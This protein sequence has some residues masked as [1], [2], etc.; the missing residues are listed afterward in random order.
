LLKKRAEYVEKNARGPAA[1]LTRT[2]WVAAFGALT[3]GC[4][5]KPAAIEVSPRSVKIYGLQ[6]NQR[7]SGAL[8]DKKRRPMPG[9]LQWSSSK[10]DVVTVD[11]AGKLQS[12][13]EGRAVVTA[14]FQTFSVSVP[15]EVIDV[16]AIEIAPATAHL[17]G[18]AGTT[19][20]LSAVVKNS[21][22]RPSSRPVSWRSLAPRV[23][24]VSADGLVTSVAP[25][26]AAIIGKVGDIEAV[27][28]VVVLIG[29]VARLEIRP[30]TALVRVGDSQ[31]F[32]TIAYG[33]EGRPYETSSATF[34]S[35]N[36]QVAS[37]NAAGIA[38]GLAAGTATIRATVAGA[39]AEATLIVTEP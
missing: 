38:S 30:A 26:T 7:L 27:S 5:A 24:T 10:S 15:V 35:S 9:A 34:Q 19:L 23:A 3:A 4:S 29:E 13:G 6:R 39:S 32:E 18:P 12:K 17:V 25:G 20:A 1:L 8:V 31:H 2:L 21:K 11:A 37:V 33:P 14:S 22:D 28:E 16:K 36:P